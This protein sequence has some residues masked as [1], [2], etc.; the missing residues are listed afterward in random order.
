MK[1]KTSR[2]LT[3]HRE[4]LHMLTPSQ[5]P[6]VL[7]AAYPI[8]TNVGGRCSNPCIPRNGNDTGDSCNIFSCASCIIATCGCDTM[9]D[10][11]G[12]G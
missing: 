12:A 9:V 2:K 11:C 8:A 6:Q 1:R 3:L 7:G 10:Q 5:L 4:T